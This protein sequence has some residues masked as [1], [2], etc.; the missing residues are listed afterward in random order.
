MRI[1]CWKSA[2]LTLMSVLATT[3]AAGQ[4][5]WDVAKD[6]IPQPSVATS[7]PGNGDPFGWRK[8]LADRGIVFG[9]EYTNDTLSNLRGGIRT[10][11]IDQGKI[12]GI[13]TV[14]FEK[15]AGWN[16]LSLFSNFFQIHNTGLIR[17]QYVGGIN[18]IA[19][20]EA[21]PATRLSELWLEQKFAND[22]ASLR[23]G[24]LAADNEFFYSELSTMFLQSDWPTIA[25]VNLPGGGPA[26]PLSTPGA[27]LK[28][29]PTNNIAWLIAA[30]NGDPAGQCGAVAEIC[31]RNGLNFRVNDPPLLMSELQLTHNTGQQDKGLA[32]TLK[33]GAW[34]HTGKF[35]DQRFATNGLPLADPS[36]SGSPQIHKGDSGVYV[37]IDQQLYRKPGGD[38]QRGVS[39]FSRVSFSPNDRNL[40]S[41]YADG[42]IVFAGLVPGR[43]NDSFG[44]AIIYSKY[45]KGTRDYDRDLIFYTGAPISVRDYEA[46]LELTYQAQIVPGWTIQP[47]LQFI[48]HPS[49]N[50]LIPRA[51]VA[52]V[53]S[54]WRF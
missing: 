27:R 22:K 5:W 54:L 24:Q 28:F 25:A 29:Q 37:V 52:G 4:A 15:M 49:G 51:T 36:S 7:L 17:E 20:I 10:G 14:D 18:T 19:A 23:I 8:S 2:I 50:S 21:L 53:R 35:D 33:L 41:F 31:N 1:K 39:V 48:W 38:Q 44:A 13:L 32:T 16:G 12:Q 46:N 34:Y 3:P 9:L 26:Y 42:G 30:Y 43:P 45:S 6:G 40:I 11:T 47:D